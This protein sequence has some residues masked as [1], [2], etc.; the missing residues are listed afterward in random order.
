MQLKHDVLVT[1]CHHYQMQMRETMTEM[2]TSG[3]LKSGDSLFHYP[4]GISTV[5]PPPPNGNHL[6]H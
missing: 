5:P 2:P 3:D 4:T 6:G 1:T